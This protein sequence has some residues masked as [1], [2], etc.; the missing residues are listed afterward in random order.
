MKV[1]LIDKNFW[2]E[3]ISKHSQNVEVLTYMWQFFRL[4]YIYYS[5]NYY[6]NCELANHSNTWMSFQND[7]VLNGP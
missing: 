5:L 2:K 1:G 3:N 7:T 6:V 4:A